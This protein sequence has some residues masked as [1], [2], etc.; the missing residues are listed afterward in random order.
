MADDQF[1]FYY[2]L[3]RRILLLLLFFVC[4]TSLVAQ[5]G[6]LV[7]LGTTQAI[8]TSKTVGLNELKYQVG[9]EFKRHR[10]QSYIRNDIEASYFTFMIYLND[11][12]EGGETTFNNLTVEP[13]QG[14]ALIFFP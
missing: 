3:S 14:T 13:K 10:D 7:T 6:F 1:D 12:Y 11:N 5:R 4:C 9:Q 2:F 8:C